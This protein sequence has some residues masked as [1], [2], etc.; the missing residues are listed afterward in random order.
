MTVHCLTC[1]I[2]D[3]KFKIVGR[4]LLRKLHGM[5]RRNERSCARY[6]ERM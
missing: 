3:Q 1:H 5:R 6:I 4:T 2:G